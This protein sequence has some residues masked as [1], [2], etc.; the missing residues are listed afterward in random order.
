M[1]ASP[2]PSGLPRGTDA[3]AGS[4]ERARRGAE[5]MLV[6]VGIMWV[7]QVVNSLDGYSLSKGDGIVPREVA[8]LK[9]IV[10]APFLHA[11]WGHLIGNT[12]PFVVLGLM[13]AVA[14]PARLLVVTAIV[15]LVAGLGTWL[16]SPS[17]SD[18]VG[19]SGVV[20][21]YAAYL[22]ARGFF[23]RRLTEIAI[24][25]VV[26]VLFGGALLSS[27]LPHAGVS[28]EDHAFGAIGGLLA[29]RLLSDGGAGGRA[30]PAAA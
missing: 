17:H 9:G 26:A 12:I 6:L 4:T 7:L 14:G 2:P 23:N 13:I 27:L 30:S 20:F 5:A 10:L 15:A 11:S 8:G 24:G 18:T 25:V 3:A 16:T 28:W 1:S 21:G 29:A 19:A 22:I